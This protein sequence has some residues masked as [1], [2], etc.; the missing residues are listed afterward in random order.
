MSIIRNT[1]RAFALIVIFAFFVA[2]QNGTEAIIVDEFGRTS[3]EDIIARQDQLFIGLDNDPKAIGYALI[4]SDADSLEDARRVERYLN[5]QTEF[6]RFND[7]KFRVVHAVGRSGLNVQFWIVPE[8]ADL[9]PY[10]PVKWPLGTSRRPFIFNRSD[11]DEGPC[12]FGNQFKVYA[13]ILN[14]YPGSK[15]HVVIW[16]RTKRQFEKEKERV[17]R[18][19]V[20]KYGLGAGKIRYFYFRH[21]DNSPRWEY[22]VVP[23]RSNG[24]RK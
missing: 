11:V 13:D 6:R 12:P 19:L 3:C 24:H 8:G 5:G 17:E 16:T 20:R 1:L 7:S 22:W 10:E 21:R 14:S 9:P 15:G 18:D 2:A 23:K 4:F